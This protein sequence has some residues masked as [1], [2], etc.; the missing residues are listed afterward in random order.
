MK[1]KT[2]SLLEE[3]NSMSPRRDRKQIIESNA[4]QII[5]TAI[6]LLEMIEKE[7]DADTAADLHKRLVNSIKTKDVKKFA[8]GVAKANED[9]RHTGRGASKTPSTRTS[10][11]GWN[12]SWPT[13]RLR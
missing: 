1:K 2:K 8:R 7:Y 3:I 11:S 4:A 5:G 12:A 9:T 6:N 13:R 10:G